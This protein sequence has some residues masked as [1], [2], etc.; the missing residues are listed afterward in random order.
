MKTTINLLETE[1]TISSTHSQ[2]IKS[3]WG[4]NENQHHTIKVDANGNSIEFNYW[5]SQNEPNITTELELITAL[6]T[7]LSEAINADVSYEDFCYELGY[8]AN[9]GEQV[10]IEC[11]EQLEKCDTLG[12]DAYESLNAINTKYEI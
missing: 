5:Q 9:E 8:D 2:L 10:Y 1:I 6:Q 11:A 3:T 4:A 7:L 12:I